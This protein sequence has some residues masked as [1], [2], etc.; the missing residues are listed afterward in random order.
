MFTEQARQLNRGWA[1]PLIARAEGEAHL[2]RGDP[3]DGLAR[4]EEAVAEEH[5]LPMPLDRARTLLVL[6]SAQRRARQRRLARQTLQR[7]LDAFRELDAQLWAAKAEAE[8]ARIGGRAP[9]SGELTPTEQRVADLVTEGKSN[10]EVAAELVI[11]VHTVESTLTSVYRKLD[12]RS[13][14][15]LA[16]KLAE[17]SER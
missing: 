4:L 3:E 15:E 2:A 14:T 5:L 7:A 1:T 8:L 13:R 12:V 11:S 16:H 10:K 6:G 9:S 17:T